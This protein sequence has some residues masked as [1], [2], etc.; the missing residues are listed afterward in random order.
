MAVRNNKDIA[1][2]VISVLEARPLVF[3]PD[4]VDQSVKAANDVLGRSARRGMDVSMGR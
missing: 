2:G 1:L 3:V 4:L